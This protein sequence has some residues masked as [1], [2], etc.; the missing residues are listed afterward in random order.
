MLLNIVIQQM[1]SDKDPELGHAVQLMVI[2][3]MLLNPENMLASLNKSE[4]TDFL[5]F[6]YKHSIQILIGMYQL[7]TSSS[8]ITY[9]V[10]L[11][12]LFWRTQRRE[13][14]KK[15]TTGA[16]NFS[17]SSSNCCLSALNITL[18]T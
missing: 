15:K 1:I 9:F 3:K 4:K 6:F 2:L 13:N 10:I 7:H 16:S 5:N 14:P 12:R 8:S 17:G 11:Q 18:T